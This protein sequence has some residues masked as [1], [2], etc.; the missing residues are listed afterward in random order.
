MNVARNILTL[1]LGTHQ[2]L[3]GVEFGWRFNSKFSP[4][5]L[6]LF[7]HFLISIKKSYKISPYSQWQSSNL[8]NLDI[9]KSKFVSFNWKIRRFLLALGLHYKLGRVANRF[10]HFTV[11]S[12]L[13]MYWIKLSIFSSTFHIYPEIKN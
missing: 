6:Y 3:V 9:C 1:L 5:L 2:N 13:V 8:A 7:M 10:S 11:K 12:G 4:S